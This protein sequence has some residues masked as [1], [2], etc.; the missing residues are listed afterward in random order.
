MMRKIVSYGLP[1]LAVALFLM[2]LGALADT[3]GDPDA[4]HLKAGHKKVE[5]VV[6]D[7]KSGIY[8]VK[9]DTGTYTLSEAA[10]GRHGHAGAK[11][12]DEMV[13][14][15]NENNMV[16]DAHPKGQTAK[17]HRSVS[18]KL[19]DLDNV[20][21]EI[22]LSTAQGETTLKI[23]PETRGFADIPQG[24][25]VTVELNEQGEVIDIHRDKR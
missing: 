9:T 4:G 25:Q 15:V 18:G 13:L 8:T 7:I 23:K 16:I 17:A 1:I 2:P 22:K 11:V 19:V 6:S 10:S 3:P 24:V 14:W 5:G 12:G 20:K 21:S